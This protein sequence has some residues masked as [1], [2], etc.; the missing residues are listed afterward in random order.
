MMFRDPL[1]WVFITKTREVLGFPEFPL[2]MVVV[3]NHFTFGL[4][5]FSG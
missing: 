2:A 3:G 1:P 5:W 4:L